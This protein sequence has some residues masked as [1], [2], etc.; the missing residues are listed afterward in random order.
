MRKT[1]LKRVTTTVVIILLIIAITLAVLRVFGEGLGS[2][3]FS[4][5]AA[6][7]ID[8]LTEERKI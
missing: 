7:M 5:T 4:W 8:I 6:L 1:K 2:D 3:N